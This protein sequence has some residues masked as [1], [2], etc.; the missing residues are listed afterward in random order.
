MR[1]LPIRKDDEVNVIKGHHKGTTGSVKAVYRKKFVIHVDRVV[2]D[3]ANGAFRAPR[4]SAP[5]HAHTARCPC[6]RHFFL[7]PLIP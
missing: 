7:T 4:S 6:P 2:A 1:S 3:K 5:Q